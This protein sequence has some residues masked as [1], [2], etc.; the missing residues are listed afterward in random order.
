MIRKAIWPNGRLS[1]ELISLPSCRMPTLMLALI[2]TDRSNCLP[3][4]ASPI[5]RS[6]IHPVDG[7]TRFASSIGHRDGD[8]TVIDVLRGRY[9]P[10]DPKL[11]TVEYAALLKEYRFRAVTGDNYAAAWVETAFADA[12]IKYVR[13][14]LPK[15]RLYIEGLPA[16][17]RRTVSLPDH[18]KLLRELRLLE[19][20][21]HIGGKDSVD[22]GRYGS[23]DHANAYSG[24]A[25]RPKA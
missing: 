19:R 24:V 9:P 17:T 15:G 5:T 21:T 8:R 12:G 25:N 11:A 13:S 1:S 7:M 10:F 6:P 2:A 14:E 3:A 22:H 16:F 18:P 23:D 4:T 20:R